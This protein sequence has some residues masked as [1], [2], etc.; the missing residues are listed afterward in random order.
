MRFIS[1][2]LS[3]A[4]VALG[5]YLYLKSTNDSPTASPEKGRQAVEQAK[6]ATDAMQKSLEQQQKRMD[7]LQQ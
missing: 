4:V 6:E 2:L 7:E 5:V 1:I 3:L